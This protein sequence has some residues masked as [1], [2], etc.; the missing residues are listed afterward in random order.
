MVV[1]MNARS[2][3]NFFGLRCCNRA[4]WEIRAVAEKM[5]ALVYQK[6]PSLFKSAGPQCLE[7]LRPEGKLSCGMMEEVR[8]RFA[9]LKKSED[10]T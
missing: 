8:A 1:T 10:E 5:L 3:I 9:E 2:L 6:A 7:G 4:Q